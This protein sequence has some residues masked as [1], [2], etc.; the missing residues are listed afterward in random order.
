MFK[1]LLWLHRWVGLTIGLYFVL[2]G[3]TGSYLVYR[4]PFQALFYPDVRKASGEPGKLDLLAA[5]QAAQRG[6]GTD[7]LPSQIWVSEDSSRNLEIG[8]S[9]LPGQGRGV[10]TAFVDPTSNEFKGSEA[11]RETFGGK[12]FIFHHDLFLGRIGRTIMAATGFMMLFLL[13]GG[14]Y[15]WWPRKISWKRALSLGPLKTPL[16]AQVRLH[17]FIGFY[18]LALMLVVT[19]SGV[20]LSRPDWF[21]KTSARPRPSNQSQSAVPQKIQLD[22]LE[23]ELQGLG[24]KPWKIRIDQKKNSVHLQT[25]KG[26]T[27]TAPAPKTMRNLQHDLHAGHFWGSLGEVLVF[28]SGL[29]PTFF[30][31]SG[32]YIWWSK[33]KARR[34]QERKVS[35]V[36][37]AHRA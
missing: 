7:R 10:R 6:I 30:Y 24:P 37:M 17:K 22:G 35:H 2:L 26:M 19:F 36:S 15:L 5:V 12:V 11:F 23:E 9:G 33:S 3:L 28:V 8:F 21:Q 20:Y 27:T 13:L 14:I 32:L 25:G 31:F 16:Q 4:E 34:P 1:K 18:S 29:I